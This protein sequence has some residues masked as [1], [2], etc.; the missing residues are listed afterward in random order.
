MKIIAAV[1]HALTLTA[2]LCCQSCAVRRSFVHYSTFFEASRDKQVSVPD[3]HISLKLI[4]FD[5]DRQKALF[6]ITNE[7]LKE[8]TTEWVSEGEFFVSR[9]WFG[10]GGLR[11]KSLGTEHALLERRG[12]RAERR[13]VPIQPPNR[14]AVPTSRESIIRSSVKSISTREYIF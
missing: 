11:L 10:T 12:A 3:T 5:L 4:S 6:E 13:I 9:L 1:L 14:T 8:S 2:L 7:Q